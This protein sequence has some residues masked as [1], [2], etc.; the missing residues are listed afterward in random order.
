MANALLTAGI[1]ES[2][3][4]DSLTAYQGWSLISDGVFFTSSTALLGI[5]TYYENYY[6][7]VINA[8]GNTV[9]FANGQTLIIWSITGQCSAQYDGV[10][11]IYWI[12]LE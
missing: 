3:G 5:F 9:A 12:Y 6:E 2:S 1:I 4:R 11:V 10:R 7:S 8:P